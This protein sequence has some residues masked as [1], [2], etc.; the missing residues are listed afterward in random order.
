[1]VLC[2]QCDVYK[3]MQDV[4][5]IDSECNSCDKEI[6]LYAGN[7]WLVSSLTEDL[8]RD[9]RSGELKRRLESVKK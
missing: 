9:V 1:M 5:A 3:N 4:D 2:E 6:D 7:R 8:I